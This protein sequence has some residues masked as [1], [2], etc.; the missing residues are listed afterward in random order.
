MIR[1]IR[2]LGDP[3]LKTVADRVTTFDAR[4]ERLV[5]DLMDTVSDPGAAGVAAP[6]I[7]VGLRAFS[8][9]VDGARGYVLNP[10]IVTFGDGELD[11]LEGCLSVPGLAYPTRRA[12]RAVVR[13]IDVRNEPVQVRG[14]G[15]LA[16]CLQ[17]EVDH[18]DG[19]LYL[20]RLDRTTQKDAYRAIRRRLA[21]EPVSSPR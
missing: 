13:G 8:Y 15:E 10:E 2:L 3:V 7:G 9:D 16:R 5:A 6:Q 19:R 11:G 20:D 1:P 12:A 18:L 14:T 4:L 17:H 21:D